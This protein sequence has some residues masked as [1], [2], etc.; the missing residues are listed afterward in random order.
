MPIYMYYNAS[1][2]EHFTVIYWDQRGSGKS[3][4]S[5]IPPE[6]M[7]LDQFIADTHEVTNWLRKRFNQNKIVL[8]GHSWGGLLGM[9]VIA[10]HPDDYQ[11]F[12][13]VSP[14]SNGPKSEQLSYEFTLNSAQQKHDSLAIATLKRIGPPVNGLYSEGLSA[15]IQQRR[16][17][18]KYGGVFHQHLKMPSSQ[19]FLRSREYNLLD[20]LKIKRIQRLSYPMAQA[21][22]PAMDLRRQIPAI[23]VPV[24]FCLG[25]YDYN[26]PSTLV[27]EYYESLKAPF[28]ELIWFEESAHAPCL[29]ESQK[30]NALVK[31]RLIRGSNSE[32]LK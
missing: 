27:A 18:Q 9:H 10:K 8:V 16:L 14:V 4:S 11:A 6:S 29:E 28:K 21:I 5:R 31:E 22:W 7:T 24:Y 15:I 25:R 30:F 2:E 19:I 23:N 1:L 20:L 13:A 12:V 26:C 17:V 32:S 3:F